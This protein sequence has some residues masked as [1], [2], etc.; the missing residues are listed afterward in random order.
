MS[1][2][3]LILFQQKKTAHFTGAFSFFGLADGVSLPSAP[4][5]AFF[6][7]VDFGVPFAFF[8]GGGGGGAA[9]SSPSPSRSPLSSPTLPPA[10]PSLPPPSSSSSPGTTFKL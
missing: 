5:A 3:L 6:L 1:A 2:A 4:A 10:P 9:S 7:L 8:A